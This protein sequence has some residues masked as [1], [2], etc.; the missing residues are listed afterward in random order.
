MA[1][2]KER[3]WMFWGDMN[4]KQNSFKDSKMEVLGNF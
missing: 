3:G 2:E 1:D 4:E